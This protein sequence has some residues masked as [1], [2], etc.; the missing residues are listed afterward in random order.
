MDGHV[1]TVQHQADAAHCKVGLCRR[2]F[3]GHGT[4]TAYR[5]LIFRRQYLIPLVL[6]QIATGLVLGFITQIL[7]SAIATAGNL[8][9]L[10]GGFTLSMALDPFMNS[11]SSTFGR[12]YGLLATTLLFITNGYLLLI[13]G[14]LTSFDVVPLGGIKFEGL[15]EI[16]LHDVGLMMMAAI[17]IAGPL[18]ACYFLAEVALG[19]LGKAAPQLNILQFGFPFKILLT[20]LIVSAAI[21]LIPGALD[22]LLNDSIHRRPQNNYAL[23]WR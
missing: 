11:Q 9:D 7:F 19:L 6:L 2:H 18:L 8:I 15:Q 14:F 5:R 3:I 16:I 12:F 23:I 4:A 20:L 22:N 17:E 1:A 10:F 13:K 21:P